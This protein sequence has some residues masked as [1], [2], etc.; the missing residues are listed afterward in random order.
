MAFKRS[1]FQGKSNS[2]YS[3]LSK[4][5]VPKETEIRLPLRID[6]V[7]GNIDVDCANVATLDIQ[8]ESDESI[9]AD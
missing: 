5:S 4:P 3:A 6:S 2:H 7:S 8:T 9:E 1:K